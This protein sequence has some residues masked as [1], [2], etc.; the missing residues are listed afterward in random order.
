MTLKYTSCASVPPGLCA[1]AHPGKALWKGVDHPR[2]KGVTVCFTCMEQKLRWKV[3]MSPSA[4]QSRAVCVCMFWVHPTCADVFPVNKAGDGGHI[5]CMTEALWMLVCTSVVSVLACWEQSVPFD[6]V[7]YKPRVL[8]APV[9]LNT[10][11]PYRHTHT[12]HRLGW[13]YF[14]IIAHNIIQPRWLS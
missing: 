14:I 10:A 2:S 8:G 12:E 7:R 9:N 6:R 1:T 13:V 4:V 5:L 11:P 3:F